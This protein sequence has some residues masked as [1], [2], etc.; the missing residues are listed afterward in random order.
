MSADLVHDA[1]PNRSIAHSACAGVVTTP[2]VAITNIA[3]APAA[4]VFMRGSYQT[5]ATETASKRPPP[6]HPRLDSHRHRAPETG[7]E[8]RAGGNR[9]HEDD[10]R[11]P[12]PRH[13]AHDGKD[14]APER[15][16]LDGRLVL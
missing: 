3:T 13:Q 14:D 4:L 5:R 9:R 11:S 2:R 7:D 8:R 1:P 15:H 6:A 16:R 10:D 12:D